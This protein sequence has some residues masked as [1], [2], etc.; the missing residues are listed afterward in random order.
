MNL[1]CNFSL[2]GLISIAEQKIK[3][4]KRAQL[5]KINHHKKNKTK[6]LRGKT[7]LCP[8]SKEQN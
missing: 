3:G 4:K 8:N 7:K 6:K 5:Q 1:K 2:Y